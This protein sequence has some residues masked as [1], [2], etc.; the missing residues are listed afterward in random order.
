MLN[1]ESE[2]TVIGEAANGA[3]AVEKSRTIAPDIVVMDLS[4]PLIEGI[5][6][7]AEITGGKGAPKVLI[8][9]QFEEEDYIRDC[10]K[11]GAGGYVLKDSL[12]AELPHAIRV[13]HDG[14]HFFSPRIAQQIVGFYLNDVVPANP[15]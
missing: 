9:S 6:A 10:M 7:T 5:N 1:D 2:I 14:G 13:V 15:H 4:I 12:V 3:D 11:A 8:I